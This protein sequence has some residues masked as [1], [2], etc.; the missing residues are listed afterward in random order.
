MHTPP[1]SRLCPNSPLKKPP[2][3]GTWP[4]T[5]ADSR[6]IIVGRVP[7]RGEHGVFERAARSG[8][9]IRLGTT[10]LS[11]SFTAN[12]RG[13]D[14]R[15]I[16]SFVEVAAA[17]VTDRRKRRCLLQWKYRSEERRVG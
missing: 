9:H 5:H 16:Y 6:G 3:V 7:S 12:M 14:W 13:E 15:A 2:G 1:S 8:T 4:T 11:I 10:G 17:S